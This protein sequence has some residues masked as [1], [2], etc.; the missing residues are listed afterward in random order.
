MKGTRGVGVTD[1]LEKSEKFE[2]AEKLENLGQLKRKL[3][4]KNYKGKREE[5]EEERSR[6]LRMVGDWKEQVKAWEYLIVK[7][8]IGH[9][10]VHNKLMVGAQIRLRVWIRLWILNMDL[11]IDLHHYYIDNIED[12]DMIVEI[13]EIVEE[14]LNLQCK[15]AKN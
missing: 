11:S 3:K 7:K 9:K 14:Q 13:V 2:G 8:Q 12:L 1:A 4:T 10:L 6:R 5:L 15:N